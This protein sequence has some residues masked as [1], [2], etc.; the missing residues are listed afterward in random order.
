MGGMFI[1]WIAA[2][3]TLCIVEA[4]TW[5]L[6]TIW[7]AFGSVAALF[8]EMAGFSIPAQIGVCLVISFVLLLFTK[9]I[10]DKKLKPRKEPTNA[11]KNI[12]KTGIVTENITP[13][14]F[15]GKVK[16]DGQVWSAVS[17][18][19]SILI[20]GETVVVDAISGVKLIV[21]KKEER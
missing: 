2:I 12:G 6:V 15:A 10:V 13:D 4:L 21:E 18:D 3:V 20:E 16:V 14:K 9:P 1:F 11:D 19:G 8:M 7:F 5:N 17:K